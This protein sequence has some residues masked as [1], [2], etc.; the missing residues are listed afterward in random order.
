M[1]NSEIVTD[2]GLV[3]GP[4]DRITHDPALPRRVPEAML[5]NIEIVFL[6]DHIVVVN[7][8]PGLLVHPTLD[9]EK[10]TLISRVTDEVKRRVGH[11]SKILVVHRI[12]RDTSGLLVMARTG[13]AVTSL[14]RQFRVHTISRCY[15]ALVQGDLQ[16]EC[17]IDRAIGR[18]RPGARRAV[19]T[20]SRDAQ[21][22]QTRVRPIERYGVATL[23]EATLGTGRTH[24]VR[25]HLT[26]LGHPV[27]GDSLY[28]DPKH[29]PTPVPR[30]ALHA[31]HLGFNHPANQ[32]PVQF[33]APLPPD[34]QGITTVLRHKKNTGKRRL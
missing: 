33:D 7:K 30:L 3:L 19:V 6:D 10:D 17:A 34:L 27:L 23:I 14:Q 1:V 5:R 21:N 22:A 28:G 11:H 18:P 2:P 13:A 24:Q 9:R 16:E 20:H 4:S 15:L 12:D 26:W 32:N 25:V 31:A 29:D 8:P